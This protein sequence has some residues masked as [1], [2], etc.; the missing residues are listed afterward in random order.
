M[1]AY[2]TVATDPPAEVVADA[3]GGAD[4][5]VFASPSSVAAY[6]GTRDMAGRPLAIPST[7]VCIGPVTAEAARSCGLTVA[8]EAA[9]ASSAGLVAALVAHRAG[10][11]GVPARGTGS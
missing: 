6:L 4:A 7:V 11:H 1:T 10:E 3:A 9:V 5:V 8:V 2:Q